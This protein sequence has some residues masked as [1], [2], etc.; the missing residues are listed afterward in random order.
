MNTSTTESKIKYNVN[1]QNFS[2]IPGSPIAYWISNQIFLCFD[3]CEKK[4]FDAMKGIQTGNGEKYLRMW[5]EVELSNTG[6]NISTHDEMIK[7]QLKWFPLT[8]GGEVRKWYGNYEMVVN[9]YND[10]AEI[11]RTGLKNF[12]L[13]ESEFYFLEGLT[14]TEVTTK[15]FACRYLPSTVLF[16]NGGPVCFYNKNLFYNL[17]LFNSKVI[18]VIMGIIAPT[19]NCGPDQV[20]AL[21]IKY[22]ENDKIKNLSKENVNKT[23][24]DWDAF[25]TSW[26]FKKHPLI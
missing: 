21:P 3:D 12:R 1:A 17:A 4:A 6:F 2:K 13:K 18:T 24:M 16:G 9:L 23:K 20:R 14:W 26:D 22:V 11:R 5:F 25:E 10:G 19:L 15:N 8:S 7:S